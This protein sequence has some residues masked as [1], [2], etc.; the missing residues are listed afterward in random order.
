M[1]KRHKRAARP[2]P[3]PRAVPRE[4]ISEDF[5]ATSVL[6]AGHV[7]MRIAEGTQ[8]LRFGLR[9]I[10]GDLHAYDTYTPSQADAMDTDAPFGSEDGYA[11]W[12]AADADRVCT[13][14]RVEI[15]GTLAETF[16][17]DAWARNFVP[18]GADNRN[19]FP[20]LDVD[21]AYEWAA[22]WLCSAALRMWTQRRGS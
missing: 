16:F 15:A 12:V 21:R 5:S 22:P 17:R 4:V 3:K 13:E 19:G 6:V 20:V 11:Q 18:R 1:S 9:L 14:L 7:I 2:R 10:Q 8:H